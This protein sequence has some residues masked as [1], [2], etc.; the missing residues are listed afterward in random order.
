MFIVGT[1]TFLVS[2]LLPT[3]SAM[4]HIPTA[5]S[6]WI[7]SAYAIGYVIAALLA[8]P[9]SDNRDKKKVLVGGFLGFALATFLC[10][11]AFTFPLM[12]LFRFL[13]GVSAAIGGPQIWASIPVVIERKYV[14]RAMG[15]VG[16]ALSVSQLAGVPIGSF[17]ASVTWRLPFLVIGGL[18][19]ALC[20]ITQLMLPTLNPNPAPQATAAGDSAQQARATRESQ[21]S[22]VQSQPSPSQPRNSFLQT[23]AS[24]LSN[25]M[26]LAV[27]L[28]YFLFQLGNFSV[29]NFIG[30]WFNKDFR[31]SLTSIGTAMIFIGIGNLIGTVF[32]S[33]LS[34]RLGIRTSL[35]LGF[36]VL[37]ALYLALP[38]APSPVFATIGLTL[39]MLVNGFIFPLFMTLLQSTSTNAR[40][41]MSSLGNAAM[42]A[43][44]SVAGII[45]GSLITAF[46]SFFG[47][48]YF[49]IIAYVLSLAVYTASGSLNGT[50]K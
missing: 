20:L 34:E 37:F 38:F 50:D 15:Y 42:Y 43:G 8:G 14:I 2:P 49:T 3:L 45:G 27:L 7:T 44:S 23:Y 5:Q 24:V 41:T 36:G 48:A 30:T 9:I 29:L 33:R 22:Q 17:L 32:G 31:L 18:S 16:A 39:V 40:S 1:D 35:L 6:G 25:R 47:I 19:L 13:A 11:F 26:S 10:G 21:P 4:Y 28:G 46:P 12:L